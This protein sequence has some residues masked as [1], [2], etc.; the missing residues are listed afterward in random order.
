MFTPDAGSGRAGCGP[1]H[2]GTFLTDLD[3]NGS[4]DAV[5]HAP[6]SL[7]AGGDVRPTRA[8]HCSSP[9]PPK[10]CLK[11]HAEL[12]L[13]LTSCGLHGSMPEYVYALHDF[14]P[15]HEDEIAFSAGDRIE[16]IEKDDMYGDGW[17]QVR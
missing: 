13:K 4:V 17:W 6:S 9:Q 2:G 5:W 8:D 7:K 11:A 12:L 1:I 10:L 3:V 16:V 14:A 15:E